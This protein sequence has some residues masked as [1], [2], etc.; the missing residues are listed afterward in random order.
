MDVEA[1]AWKQ[2]KQKGINALRLEN[3]IDLS[4]NTLCILVK[5]KSESK[6]LISTEFAVKD[7]A[8]YADTCTLP[9]AIQVTLY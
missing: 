5:V 2:A 7:L 4:P 1:D 9:S 3:F 8:G 6:A